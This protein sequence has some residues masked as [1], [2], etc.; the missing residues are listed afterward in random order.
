MVYS[1]SE[2][3]VSQKD[4]DQVN[5]AVWEKDF[6]EFVKDTLEPHAVKVFLYV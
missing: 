1:H 2:A 4:A 6:R 3:T 5:V